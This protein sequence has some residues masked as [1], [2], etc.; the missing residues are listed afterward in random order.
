M[1]AELDYERFRLSFD[2][3][4]LLNSS[5]CESKC[6]WV[7]ENDRTKDHGSSDESIGRPTK[8]WREGR[9]EKV[10]ASVEQ[11]V[12]NKSGEA[13]ADNTS[14]TVTERDYQQL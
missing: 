6:I 4:A 9:Y 2:N 13:P 10:G 8:K 12:V 14:T 5:V 1:R 11:S 3:M 7:S